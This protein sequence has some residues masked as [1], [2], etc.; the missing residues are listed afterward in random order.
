[1]NIKITDINDDLFNNEVLLNKKYILVIFWSKFCGPC[2]LLISLL[3]DI[4]KDYINKIKFVKLNVNE[5]NFIV[6]KYNIKNVPTIIL[7][8]KGVLLSSKI[9]LLDKKE[10]K[11]FL[12]LYI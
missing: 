12:N 6:K 11:K 10:L 2:K 4:Y 7:F 5:S 3:K 1:M 8:N 9:G